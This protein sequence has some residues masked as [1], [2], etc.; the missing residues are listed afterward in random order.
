MICTRVIKENDF[1]VELGLTTYLKIPVE[2]K[3]NPKHAM[4]KNR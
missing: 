3:S 2:E 4:A 1:I